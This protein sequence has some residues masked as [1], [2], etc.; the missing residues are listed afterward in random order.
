MKNQL[1]KWAGCL[2][3]PVGVGLAGMLLWAA[4][5]P[6]TAKPAGGLRGGEGGG[7]RASCQAAVHSAS[8]AHFGLH[9][10]YM[11]G[12]AEQVLRAMGRPV[13]NPF[14]HGGGRGDGVNGRH[15][16][17]CICDVAAILVAIVC[18]S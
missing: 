7:Q 14:R 18:P 6:H 5:W 12:L 15:V 3:A 1:K 11:N 4:A 9:F 17:E 8:R 16:A 13:V 10:A 2:C